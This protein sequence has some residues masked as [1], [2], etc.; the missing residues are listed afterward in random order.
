[1]EHVHHEISWNNI[2][3]K[4]WLGEHERAFST[5]KVRC[6]KT[7]G[8]YHAELLQDPI[9]LLIFVTFIIQQQSI[10]L[11][12]LLALQNDFLTT[13]TP[14]FTKHMLDSAWKGN[15]LSIF[16]MLC[17]GFHISMTQLC[18]FA[19][20]ATKARI[21]HRPALSPLNQTHLCHTKWVKPCKKV[22]RPLK[23]TENLLQ[24]CSVLLI[25][26]KFKLNCMKVCQ[27]KKFAPF[28][29]PYGKCLTAM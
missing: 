8:F 5:L 24:A 11:N 10:G 16:S 20:P 14:N 4:G 19:R 2:L 3:E 21:T 12:K 1:M 13:H 22:S 18:C 17:L 27:K 29:R 26:E 15:N 23:E 28:P 6:K 7:F 9:K 25:K